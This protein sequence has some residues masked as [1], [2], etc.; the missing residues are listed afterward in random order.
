MTLDEKNSRKRAADELIQMFEKQILEGTLAEGQAL[1]PE[2]E[3]VQAFGVSRTVV[4]EAVL[5]LSNKGLVKARPRFRP[6]VTKPGYDTAVDVVGSVVT[7]LLGEPG[8]IRNLFDIR[9]MMEASLAREA[10]LKATSDDIARLEKALQDNK[11]AIDDSEE[12]YA[13]DMAFHAVLYEIPDNPVLP[14]IQRAYVDWLENHWRQMPRVS[15]RNQR[16]Y[17]AHAAIFDAILRRDP[18][19]A[20][21]ALRA[22]LDQAWDQVCQTFEEL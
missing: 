4:R 18:D 12:F 8:G 6:I 16:N 19:K 15:T 14:A 2:R 7:R 20:E 21:A 13:T 9:I 3:I 22:H 5:A 10:A 1:P 11:T 17:E